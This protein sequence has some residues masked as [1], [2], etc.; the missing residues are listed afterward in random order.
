MSKVLIADNGSQYTHLIKRMCR[1][2]GYDSAIAYSE[3][4]ME[5]SINDCDYVVISG[6]P[7]SVKDIGENVDLNTIEKEHAVGFT[8]LNDIKQGKLSIPCLGICFGHQMMAFVFGGRVE[9]G[10]RAEYGLTE[11]EVVK[12]GTLLENMPSRFKAWASHF[13]EVVKAP[14][15]FEILAQSSVCKV[16]AME[17]KQKPLFAVQFHPEVWHTEHGEQIFK[18]FLG[19]KR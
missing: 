3:T 9:K 14:D 19:I 17:H 18:N 16:E 13:D 15:Q 2:L 7:G 5:R 8:L 10:K 6:G 11:I 1:E 4:E 12:P